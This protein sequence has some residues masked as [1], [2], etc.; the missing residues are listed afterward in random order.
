MA[1]VDTP[2]LECRNVSKAFG[3]VQALYRVDFE[4]RRGEVMALVGDNGAGK[5]TLIKS[6]A[7][8]Y[9]FDEGEVFFE[10]ELRRHPRPARRRQ[11][12]ASR[13]STR[14]SHS[15]TTSTSSPTCSSAASGPAPGFVLDES[16]ME[17]GLA[18]DAEQP[19]GH[20]APLGPPAR[21]RASPAASARRWRSRSPSC[22]TRS[23]SSSTSRPPRSASRR[24]AR[25]STSC[26]ASPSGTS[27]SCSSPTTSTTSSR[28]R[29]GSRSSA[30]ASG[31][32]LLEPGEDDPAGGRAR[33]HRRAR[34][35]TCRA[36]RAP[37]W[38]TLTSRATPTIRLAA[39]ARP[40]GACRLRARPN[41]GQPQETLSGYVR[42]WWQ[43]VETGELGLASDHRRA[44]R[45]RH[46]LRPARRHLPH[47]AQLH[48]PLA[49]DGG[50]RDDRDRGRLRAPD[51]GDR[52][53]GCLRQRG[54]RSR[55]DAAPAPRRPWLALVAGDPGSASGHD[56]DRLPSGARDHEGRRP[57]L[58]GH[59]GGPPHLVRRRPDPD[60]AGL[61]RSG[62]SGSRTTPS[63]ASRTTFSR[64]RPAGSSEPW[65][66]SPTRSRSSTPRASAA[67]AACTGSRSR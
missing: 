36:W 16:S 14:T 33:H 18:R 42:R 38:R 24:L 2:L 47:R 34:S 43:G 45:H 41:G 22:G 20:D 10:G 13:S 65:R 29:T 11:A 31:S 48:E 4:V 5:S 50:D 60:D 67:P 28:P 3:A 8:I 59:P 51:R 66:C 56:G 46:R 17:I 63:S 30:S 26:G 49:A 55:D 12:T 23:S 52:P 32:R 7:G 27:A 19:V 39:T 61:V 57:V 35:T 1:T 58:R 9:P 64:R 15:R 40:R 53:L 37:R 54:R 21:G 44:R 25:C 62:R 6:I